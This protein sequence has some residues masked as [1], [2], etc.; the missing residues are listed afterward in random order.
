MTQ[1]GYQTATVS[2]D[3]GAQV[4][5]RQMTWIWPPPTRWPR[6]CAAVAHAGLLLLDL[7]GLSFCDARGLRAFVQIAKL[8]D[9]TVRQ[10]APR[11]FP[12]P[13]L[14]GARASRGRTRMTPAR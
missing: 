13:G 1:G 8:A 5:P 6:G 3:G 10:L 2:R 11:A 12:R 4:C 7:G 14:A 9:R